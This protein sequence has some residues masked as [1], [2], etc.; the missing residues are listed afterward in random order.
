MSACYKHI[1]THERS[2]SESE[3]SKSEVSTDVQDG[4]NGTGPSAAD[5][6]QEKKH[7]VGI[8]TPILLKGSSVPQDLVQAK[9][10]TSLG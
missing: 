6:G 3:N 4:G 2:K 8:D 7:V 9:F 1:K 5:S 10:Y